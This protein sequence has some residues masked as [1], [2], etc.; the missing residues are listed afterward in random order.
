[1]GAELFL[2]IIVGL[3]ILLVIVGSLPKKVKTG[4]DN[5]SY[6]MDKRGY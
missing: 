6:Y 1:M 3:L 2:G 5:N 4:N